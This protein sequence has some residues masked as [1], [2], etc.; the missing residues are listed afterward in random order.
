MRTGNHAM[1]VNVSSGLGFCTL[2]KP[3][4]AGIN[5]SPNASTF[6][7]CFYAR[8]ASFHTGGSPMALMTC[9]GGIVLYMSATNSGQIYL[10]GATATSE[11]AL[12][13]NTWHRIEVKFVASGTCE[14]RIDGAT[15]GTCT[16]NA[17]AATGWTIGAGSSSTSDFYIDDIAIRDDDWVGAG[18][19]NVLVP[20]G[21]GGD[22]QWSA[23]AGSAYQCVDEIPYN[24]DTDY[25]FSSSNATEHFHNFDM[26]PAATAGVAG[27]IGTVKGVCVARKVSSTSALGI[28]LNRSG[29]AVPGNITT[30]YVPY[31][32][33]R[34]L[35]LSSQPW[36]ASTLDAVTAGFYKG[37]GNSAV[38]RVTAV[39]FMVW[40]SGQ[41][42]H[43]AEASLTTSVALAAAGLVTK[44]AIAALTGSVTV[45]SV[46]S[47]TAQA[48]TALSVS[49]TFA[50]APVATYAGAAAL[51]NSIT[52]DATATPIPGGGA[53]SLDATAALAAAAKMRYGGAAAL[54]DSASLAGAGTKTLGAAAALPVSALI[55]GTAQMAIGAAAALSLSALLAAAATTLG[56]DRTAFP[57]GH[58]SAR[59]DTLPAGVA[60]NRALPAGTAY[61][62]PLPRGQARFSG[63]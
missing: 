16:G 26:T 6:Y 48:L 9:G 37:S 5:S 21:A 14:L 40:C 2:Q 24:S 62:R 44:S 42:T 1:R 30:S 18:Q 45:A 61:S 59:M 28:G 33:V 4:A 60:T 22:A 43:E 38:I 25:V 54:T 52:L 51:L 56:V 15:V 3:D 58:G 19:V 10:S 8:F 39:Y 13:L 55:A 12:T 50:A 17:N 31:C 34:D 32:F 29:F 57:G 41:V 20:V 63:G 11:G 27:A 49:A 35:D 53:A 7:L 46:A 47:L 23:S 36:D